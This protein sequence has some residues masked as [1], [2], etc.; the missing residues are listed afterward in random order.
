M[1]DMNKVLILTGGY[2]DIQWAK[3]WLADKKFDYC[4]AADRGLM[5]ADRLGLDID[6]L[7]GDYDSVDERVLERYK[8]KVDFEIQVHSVSI[9]APYRQSYEVSSTLSTFT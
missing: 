8:K 6:F 4:I 9:T 7:L 5:Y 1:T 2:V 3:E